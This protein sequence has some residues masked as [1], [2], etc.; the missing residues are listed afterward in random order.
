METYFSRPIAELEVV[1]VLRRLTIAYPDNTPN[2]VAC[3]VARCALEHAGVKG[4]Y[5]SD[6]VGAAGSWARYPEASRR[7]QWSRVTNPSIAL[8]LSAHSRAPSSSLGQG[9]R[10]FGTRRAML[11]CLS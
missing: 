10:L 4:V 8:P 2:E 7:L 3:S 9:L 1:D 11:G 6:T 5:I